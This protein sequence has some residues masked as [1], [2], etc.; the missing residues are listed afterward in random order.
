MKRF[1]AIGGIAAL[2]FSQAP[3][4][5]GAKSADEVFT[6]VLKNQS[7][8][9]EVKKHIERNGGEIISEI[10]ELG[11]LQVKAGGEIIPA[12][13][14]YT[15]VQSIGPSIEMKLPAETQ[16]TVDKSELEKMAGH[17]ENL[18]EYA[19]NELL[20]N[21]TYTGLSIL[22]NEGIRLPEE[23]DPEEMYPALYHLFQWDIKRVTNY[24]ASYEKGKGSHDVVVGIIDTGVDMEHPDLKANLLG[25]RNYVPANDNGDTTETG[26]PSDYNDRNGHGSHVAGAI[27]GK[28]LILGVAPETGYRAYRVFGAEGGA[29]TAT[30][31]A[32]I[33]GAAKDDVDVISMSLGGYNVFGQIFWTDPATG[34]KYNLGNEVA[35]FQ[36]Y[37][38]AVKYAIDQ[39][40]TVVAAAGNDGLNITNKAEVTDF[41]N[42]EYAGEGYHFVGAG[43]E[44]PGSLPGVV[45]VSATGPED[46]IA[47]YSNHGAGFIDVTAPGGDF[48][49]YPSQSYPLDMNFGAY[50]DQD[51]RFMAGTSMATPKVS[52]VAAL[53]ISQ[54]GKMAPSKVA[55]MVQKSA[56]D[57]GQQGADKLYGSGMVQAPYT[58]EKLPSYMEW[59]KNFGGVANEYGS[60]VI[61]TKDGG[62]LLLGASMTYNTGGGSD[63]DIFMVKTG[64]DGRVEWRRT[65]GTERFDWG[66]DIV[67]TKDGYMMLGYKGDVEDSRSNIF[68]T[69]LNKD[70][71]TAW[72][73][74]IGDQN[75]FEGGNSF[76]QTSDGGYAI[77]GNKTVND[78]N[79]VYVLKVDGNGN[80]QWEKTFGGDASDTSSKIRATKDGGFIIAGQTYSVEMGQYSDYYLIKLGADGSK[81]WEKSFGGTKQEFL[82]DVIENEQGELILTGSTQQWKWVGSYPIME[83]DTELFKLSKEGSILWKKE[84]N[85]PDYDM[86]N[87]LVKADNGEYLAIGTKEMEDKGADAYVFTFNEQGTIMAEQTLGGKAN[88]QG[89]S[90][91]RT[92]DGGYIIFG[93]SSSY[94]RGETDTDLYLVKVNS[95]FSN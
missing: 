58:P 30:V 95:L 78:A 27:A 64:K 40:S 52:A 59:R 13:Q 1:L 34:K 42:R 49:R 23:G 68:L 24:G 5:T 70:G 80:K 8:P 77:T 12:L 44:A 76:V 37:K 69:K 15:P 35:D 92:K 86:V 25:G 10:P 60:K 47:S 7:I 57:I 82:Y 85:L 51:Y 18:K 81:Q 66:N 39:G 33:V 26:N 29:S 84:L 22:Q 62:Y 46:M 2:L 61:P 71:T 90:I 17:A 16:K 79:D 55:D 67:E 75:K 43:M 74:L 54:N 50:K 72:E 48:Q 31:A 11:V 94:H 19:G 32:A 21:S 38:R 91:E 9:Q 36:V 65:L 28:G 20:K 45:T 63:A 93:H 6:V 87:S 89:M 56:E 53:L 41:L 83:Y 73:K 3:A 14:K 88:D 4:M